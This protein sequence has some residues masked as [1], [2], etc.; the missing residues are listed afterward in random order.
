M[1]CEKYPCSF[2]ECKLNCNKYHLPCQCYVLVGSRLV[3]L[4]IYTHV[5]SW[6][7]L[8]RGFW[9]SILSVHPAKIQFTTIKKKSKN[10]LNY[11]VEA[12]IILQIIKI[13][14]ITL[15]L[16]M[17][18]KIHMGHVVPSGGPSQ[19]Y[20]ADFHSKSPLK[21]LNCEYCWM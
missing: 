14:Q 12:F 19:K 5:M 21:S 2:I 15:I 1:A 17:C 16:P 20:P 3:A 18:E 13:N 10:S 6:T 4:E 11:I 7:V 8:W 9:S